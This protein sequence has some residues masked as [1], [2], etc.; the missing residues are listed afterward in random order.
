[1]LKAFTEPWSNLLIIN[2]LVYASAVA[3]IGH[4]LYI[5]NNS[6]VEF[7]GT[8]SLFV[9]VC[10]AWIGVTLYA[11]RFETDD[12]IHRIFVLLQILGAAALTINIQG[13]LA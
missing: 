11:A 10:W 1:L 7:I 6:I 4:S 9:P 5:N 12:L 8:I 3:E 13:A 2:S